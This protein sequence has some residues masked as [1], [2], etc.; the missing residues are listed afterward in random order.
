M[1]LDAEALARLL[2]TQS[3]VVTRAQLGGLGAAKHDIERMVRRRE[4][5]ALGRATFIDH[6]GEPTWRQRAW[7]AVLGAG[8]AALC[9]D[10]ASTTPD[11]DAPIQVAIAEGRRVAPLAGVRLHRMPDLEA[12]VR[13]TSSPACLRPEHNALEIAHRARDELDVVR[14]LTDEVNA[15]RTTPERLRQALRAR[16]RMRRRAFVEAVIADLEAGTC[17]VLEHGYLDLVARPHGFP[18]ADQQAVRRIGGRS[19]YRDVEYAGLGVVVELDGAT[20]HASW[21][22]GGRDADRDLDD[23]AAERVTA[24]LRWAQVYGR[25]CATA[26]RLVRV[27]ESRGW[28]GPATLCGPDCDLG[29]SGV[30]GAQEAP[31]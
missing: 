27:F 19:E 13:W 9:L 5:V 6:T 7:V 30:P 15:R 29:G 22:A 23:L 28:A 1:A 18:V 31:H 14:A 21:V 3:G 16:A 11:E 26:A 8:R 10:S 2:A 25:P 20:G 12:R 24:R 17:S 4:L